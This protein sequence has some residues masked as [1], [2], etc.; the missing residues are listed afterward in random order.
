MKILAIGGSGGMGRFAVKALQDLETIE[1]IVV[2]DLNADSAQD[3]ANEMNDKVSA[4]P[5]DVSDALALQQAMSGMDVVMNTC[6]P[7]F[8]SAYRSCKPRLT[9]VVTTLTFVMIGSQHL[10]CLR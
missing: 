7:F 8:V 1:Q 9:R 6:G 2:A 4:M 5:L 10:K 3:F